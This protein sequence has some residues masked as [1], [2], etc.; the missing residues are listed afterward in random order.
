MSD[1]D[2]LASVHVLQTPQVQIRQQREER[3]HEIEASGATL[4]HVLKAVAGRMKWHATVLENNYGY[5]KPDAEMHFHA[6]LEM[7]LFA[8]QIEEMLSADGW[9]TTKQ[10]K[11]IYEIYPAMWACYHEF[12]KGLPITGTYH[13]APES[14]QCDCRMCQTERAQAEKVVARKLPEPKPQIAQIKTAADKRAERAAR[15]QA[16]TDK[17]L[18]AKKERVA[19]KD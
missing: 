6:H 15:A 19:K 17:R 10:Q 16:R 7:S 13:P 9:D 8:A 14:N 11:E 12:E 4:M 18:A 3:R 5:K 1:P 2:K